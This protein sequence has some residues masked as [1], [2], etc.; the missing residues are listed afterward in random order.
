MAVVNRLPQEQERPDFRRSYTGMLLLA[1]R[2][3][4]QPLQP[5][6]TPAYHI[7]HLLGPGEVF[8]FA[9]G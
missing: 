4:K 7:H 2:L 6:M 1:M 9:F 5:R 8:G 3:I